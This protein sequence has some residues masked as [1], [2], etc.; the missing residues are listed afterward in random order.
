M[1]LVEE[2]G[3]SDGFEAREGTA[4]VG[5]RLFFGGVD[6]FDLA[7]EF[8]TPLFVLS[9][10]LI[11]SRL[12]ELRREFLE[13]YDNAR[14]AYASK[15]FLCMA[16]CRIVD[17]AGLALDVVS[18]GEL[19]TAMKAGFPAGRIEFHGNNKTRD[20]LELALSYGVGRFIVDAPRELG[21]IEDILRSGCCKPYRPKA[22]FRV[23]PGVDVE[24]HGHIMT[25]H[26]G[27]KFGFPVDGEELYGLIGE[28]I[29]SELADFAGI[30]FHV[31]SQL[32]TNGSHIAATRRALDVLA[33]VKRRFGVEAPELNIGGGFGIRYVDGEA[34]VSYGEF[35]GPV[36][37]EV[38][39]VCAARGMKPPVV[40]VEPGRS[41]VGQAGV[42]LYTVGAIRESGGGRFVA[43][44]GGMTDNI[45]PA[46]YGAEY[47]AVIVNKADADADGAVALVGKCCESGDRL[48]EGARLAAAEPG[49][50]VAVFATGAYGYSM[51]SNYNKM[52]LPAVALVED[53]KARL[54][55]KRQ[56]YDDLISRDLI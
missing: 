32:F 25:G 16:M 36:M 47:E 31:G 53:G 29:D 56:T 34:P 37:D 19:Y 24:T 46:L 35:L 5:G 33:E 2:R 8:G 15:A 55:V 9:R 26:A 1:I 41:V 14:A 11:C 21:M 45:R 52:P 23:N 7:S 38:T 6:L 10:D 54:I 48:I 40:T 39:S 13:R 50:V 22:L 28:A 3:C 42:T 44:D 27:S 49:D 30:H 43:V 18:G 17:E 20:E 4:V 12:G 51:A